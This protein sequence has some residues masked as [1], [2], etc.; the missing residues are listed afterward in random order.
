MPA[1]DT[2][3]VGT[4][5]RNQPMSEP[6]WDIVLHVPTAGTS[7]GVAGSAQS[8]IYRVQFRPRLIGP[9]F[10]TSYPLMDSRPAPG[11]CRYWSN[12]GRERR[13]SPCVF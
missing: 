9:R 8:D 1:L 3:A 6:R 5:E 11:C 12:F 7:Q 10:L 4:T 2:M 13:G